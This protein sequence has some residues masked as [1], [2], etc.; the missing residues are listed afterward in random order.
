MCVVRHGQLGNV[1]DLYDGRYEKRAGDWHSGAQVGTRGVEE[2]EK[3]Q[4]MP[5]SIK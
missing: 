4:R 2:R 5:V 3:E 1:G